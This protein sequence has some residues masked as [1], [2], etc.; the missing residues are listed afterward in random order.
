MI[1]I[2]L[3][4]ALGALSACGV[5][6][7]GGQVGRYQART[8]AKYEACLENGAGECIERKRVVREEP[9]RRY[10][11]LEL[12]GAVGRATGTK[13]PETIQT[14]VE[15]IGGKG[16]LAVGV[17]AGMTSD[18]R[19]TEPNSASLL[20]VGH[21]AATRWIGLHG[22]LGVQPYTRRE[23]A[24]GMPERA[25]VGARAL[26]GVKAL[27]Y[28]QDSLAFGLVVEADRTVTSFDDGAAHTSSLVV[29]FT[30]DLAL[31]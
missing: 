29:R 3:L 6:F 10:W 16:A 28:R 2:A 9:A 5:A 24:A 26:V 30:S 27:F 11:G 12:A 25:F 8:V 18:R 19:V 13:H 20:A 31:F 21:L 4:L 7:G 17:R 23:D 14:S 22:G 1:R 15:L